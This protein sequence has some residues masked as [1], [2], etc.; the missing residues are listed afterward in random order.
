MAIDKTDWLQLIS[1]SKWFTSNLKSPCQCTSDQSWY[2]QN[3]KAGGGEGRGKTLS[4]MEQNFSYSY[5][6]QRDAGRVKRPERPAE[7]VC[8]L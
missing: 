7:I 1:L 2:Q 5:K 3:D 4:K 6:L 8:G